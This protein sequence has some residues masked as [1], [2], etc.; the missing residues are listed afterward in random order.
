MELV[1]KVFRQAY[2]HK[3]ACDHETLERVV[4][5]SGFA[6]AERAQFGVSLANELAIGFAARAHDS[7]YV[8]R[9]QTV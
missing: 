5:H 6:R 1:N 7:L 8:E 2:T 4:P 3:F 9:I